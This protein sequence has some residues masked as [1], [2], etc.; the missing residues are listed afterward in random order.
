MKF[1]WDFFASM[2]N[3]SLGNQTPTSLKNRSVFKLNIRPQKKNNMIF[4]TD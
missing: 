3:S 4:R 2:S 1:S